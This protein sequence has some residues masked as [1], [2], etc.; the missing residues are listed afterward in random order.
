LSELGNFCW[1]EL[2]TRDVEKAKKFYGGVIGWSFD[3]MPMRGA[4]SPRWATSLSAV[5]SRS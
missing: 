5:Y 3:D 2:M 4:G 1:N